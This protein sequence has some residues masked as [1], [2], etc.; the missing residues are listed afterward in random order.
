MSQD[1]SPHPDVPLLLKLYGLGLVVF[2]VW[3]FLP[4][5]QADVALLPFLLL[6]LGLSIAVGHDL[7]RGRKSA[8]S[9]LLVLCAGS[10]VVGGMLWAA[11]FPAGPLLVAAG[12]AL[13]PLLLVAHT[14]KHTLTTGGFCGRI[15]AALE[16]VLGEGG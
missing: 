1:P 12:V 13:A 6:N 8:L 7:Y 3:L 5:I 14:R 15:Y 11:A 9:F 10:G 2:A 4:G 16:R